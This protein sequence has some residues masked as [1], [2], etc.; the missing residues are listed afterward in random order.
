MFSSF[1]LSA[2]IILARTGHPPSRRQPATTAA[3][4]G[5]ERERTRARAFGRTRASDCAREQRRA[6]SCERR[7]ARAARI[8]AAA[9]SRWRFACHQSECREHFGR[10]GRRRRRWRRQLAVKRRRRRASSF[11]AR[12]SFSAARLRLLPAH[13]RARGERPNLA[14]APRVVACCRSSII[15]HFCMTYCRSGAARSRALQQVSVLVEQREAN[16]RAPLRA[17]SQQPVSARSLQTSTSRRPSSSRYFFVKSGE[18][19][20]S[21]KFCR[22]SMKR[23]A[24]PPSPPFDAPSIFSMA[25]FRISQSAPRRRRLCCFVS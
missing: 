1:Y 7:R 16:C 19:G 3:L 13:A 8:V 18:R 12:V 25:R 14:R 4:N 17:R 24:P 10:G 23:E 20:K 6:A 22:R 15:A 11:G 9:S 21:R 5:H 2:R